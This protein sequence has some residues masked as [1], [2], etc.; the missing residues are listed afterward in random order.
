MFHLWTGLTI[1]SAALGR[2]C[3][4]DKGYYKL[5]PNLFT[6]LVAG[7]AKCRKSTA[8]NIGMSIL[9][10]VPGQKIISGKISPEKFI[11]EL[12]P[13]TKDANAEA[14]V[15]A[16]ELSVFLTKQN[17]GEPL[18]HVLTDVFDCPD[19]FDYKTKNSGQVLLKNVFLSIIAATTPDGVAQGIPPSALLE[20]FASRVLFVFQ[21]DTERSNALPVLSEEEMEMK[22]ELVRWLTRIAR[23]KGQFVLDDE[24]R[25]WYVH[26]Y[27]HMAPPADKRLEGMFG[28]KHD[29]LLRLGMLYAAAE[30]R[31]VIDINDITAAERS[32]DFLEKCAPGAL[33]EIGGDD[34]SNL[35]S[36]AKV[37]IKRLKRITHSEFLRLMYPAR[38]DTFKVILDT[39]I[40]SGL[41]VVDP[42]K[43]HVYCDPDWLQ[44]LKDQPESPP[45]TPSTPPAGTTVP[46]G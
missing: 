5:Y 21:A 9:R 29:H 31:M 7:S 37:L 33:Q 34:K 46:P 39:L 36:R 45:D 12:E 20:G 2:K 4:I 16:S 41:A 13:E 19:N 14:L 8:I 15:H 22:R 23:F 27:K 35:L 28:R 32:I 1:I 3:Y 24:A 42:A 18:I 25:G 11:Q 38:A 44:S 43:P 17:Y 6:I 40:Q 26:W 10:Q 30:D